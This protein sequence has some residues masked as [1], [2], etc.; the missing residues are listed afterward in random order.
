MAIKHIRDLIPGD[1]VRVALRAGRHL[2]LTPLRGERRLEP[3]SRPSRARGTD[4]TVVMGSILENDLTQGVM[5][6]CVWDDRSP[7]HR[8]IEARVPYISILVIQEFIPPEP[9]QR[10]RAQPRGFL[11][12]FPVRL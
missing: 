12:L 3:V 9:L 7:N 4:R 11:P 10:I 1:Q 8:T 5:R 6:L 2:R